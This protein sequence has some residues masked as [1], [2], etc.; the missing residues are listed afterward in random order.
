MTAERNLSKDDPFIKEKV[1]SIA[2][3]RSE[4][5]AIEEEIHEI[6]LARPPKQEP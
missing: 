4:I 2:R 3:M 1:S 5:D 6:Q